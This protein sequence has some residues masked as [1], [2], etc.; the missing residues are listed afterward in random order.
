MLIDI[1]VH[2]SKYSSC[3]RIDFEEAIIQ[4]KGI[5]LDG[6]CITDH[7]SNGIID[8]ANELSKKHNF[9]VIV[10]MELLTYEGDLLVFGLEEVPQAHIAGKSHANELISLINQKG[11]IA[12]SAHP[13]RNNGRGMGEF[14]RQIDNLSGIEVFNG[15]TTFENNSRA[16]H[17][18]LELG[19]PCLGGSDAHRIER[20]GKYATSFSDGIRDLKDFINA[21]KEDEF[22]PVEYNNNR[23]E[24][25]KL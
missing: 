25:V 4:A 16:Y 2:T 18:G 20:I 22:F 6:I 5:G 3:S 13:F 11:G 23:F 9:L 15:N 19:I 10:G 12:L 1:H 7:E 8:E 14:I 24:E 21:V 17:L